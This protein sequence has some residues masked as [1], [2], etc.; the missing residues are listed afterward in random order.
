MDAVLYT[1]YSPRPD[2]VEVNSIGVQTAKLEAWCKAKG[3]EIIA[4]Y[5]DQALSGGTMERPGLKLALDHVTEYKGVLCCASLSRLARNTRDALAIADR[6]AKA[7]AGLVLLDLD[8]DTTSPMGRCVFTILSAVAELERNQ[9]RQRTSETMHKLRRDGRRMS[10][11]PPYGWRVDPE[12][13][14]R[15]LP[16][17]EEREVLGWLLKTRTEQPD[18]T[19]GQLCELVNEAGVMFRGEPWQRTT[20]RRIVEREMA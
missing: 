6:L 16:A 20:L 7:G 13:P 11:R 2:D 1:R 10:G 9:I 8:L 12:N 4:R 3:H 15:L 14:R 18:L 19:W 5:D 17:E